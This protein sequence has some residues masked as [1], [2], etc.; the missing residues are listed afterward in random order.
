M[1]LKSCAAS[2]GLAIIIVQQP[3]EGPAGVDAVLHQG[4]RPE[5]A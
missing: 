2:R 1:W 5:V 4:S 3:T